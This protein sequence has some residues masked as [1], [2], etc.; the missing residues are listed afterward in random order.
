MGV[1]IGLLGD[2]MLGRGVAQ[3]L[4]ATPPEQLW[5]HELRSLAESLD[6]V[7]AN[8]ECCLSDRGAPTRLVQGK[9]FF[10]R[11]P[12]SGALALE[13]MNVRVGGL[14][15][16]HALDYGEDALRD[17]LAELGSAGIATAGAGLGEVEARRA[18]VVDA[19]DVRIG[20]AAVSDH[21]REYAAARGRWGIAVADLRRG[22][23]TW[24]AEHLERL[25]AACDFV[26]AFPHWGHNMTTEPT[27]WQRAAAREMQ[28]LGADL[29]AGHS[30]HCFHGIEWGPRGPILSDLGDALDDYRVDP[31]LRNDLGLLA[32]WRPGR[33]DLELIGLAL[34][35][36][37]TDLAKGADADWIAARLARAS[38]ALG[39]RVERTE[40]QRFIALPEQG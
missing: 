18:A 16:N 14:A 8:V 12:P 40:E 13:A 32:V 11:G 26:I 28:E 9:P 29:V 17:T 15:N 3:T 4:A 38:E 10:F 39:V 21:P 37:C 5:S 25:R 6:L 30:S 33:P 36:A 1:A 23:P 2:V 24:L 20:V 31:A 35:Y 19:G 22:V 27:D 7:V 34:A